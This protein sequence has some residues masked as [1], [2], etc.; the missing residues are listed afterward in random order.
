MVVI[1]SAG[2]RTTG[3]LMTTT[4]AGVERPCVQ[5]SS[6]SRSAVA[7][8][9]FEWADR[10]PVADLPVAGVE[11]GIITGV[12]GYGAIAYGVGPQGATA[13]VVTAMNGHQAVLP[14]YT[15]PLESYFAIPIPEPVQVETLRFVTDDNTT[16]AI[17]DVPRIPAGLEGTYGG[18]LIQQ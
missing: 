15:R 12:P 11:E 4:M 1:T 17:V 10:Q 13:V 16:L 9:L 7:D 5:R 2:T 18:V 3:V 14:L 6:G 8:E